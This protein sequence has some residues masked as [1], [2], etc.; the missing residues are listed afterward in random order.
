[1]IFD[2]H[3]NYLKELNNYIKQIVPQQKEKQKP[4][5]EFEKRLNKGVVK[6]KDDYFIGTLPRSDYDFLIKKGAIQKNRGLY[7]EKK[8]LPTFYKQ[9]IQQQEERNKKTKEQAKTTLQSLIPLLGLELLEKQDFIDKVFKRLNKNFIKE[10]LTFKTTKADISEIFN[11]KLQENKKSFEE[12]M[13]NKIENIKT[14]STQETNDK[15]K[16]IFFYNI[17]NYVLNNVNEGLFEIQK[18]NALENDIKSFYWWHRPALRPSDR[19]FHRKHYNESKAGK[20]F[21]FNNLPQFNGQPDY[22][23]KL[24]NCHCRAYIRKTEFDRAVE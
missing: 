4:A 11:K 22:P 16:D 24:W 14:T 18:E 21:Y 9:V 6:Y 8:K 2:A 5:T 19:M 10:N 1:M 7:I 17:K 20:K 3:E 23:G 13:A 12:Y 15:I